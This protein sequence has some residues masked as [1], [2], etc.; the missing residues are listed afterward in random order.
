MELKQWNSLKLPATVRLLGH[1]KLI[2]LVKAEGVE[3]TSKAVMYCVEGDTTPTAWAHG[4]YDLIEEASMPQPQPRHFF[5]LWNPS[6]DKVPTQRFDSEKQAR[7]VAERMARQFPGET[8]Y[9]MRAVAGVTT[10]G[11][12]VEELA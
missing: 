11:V 7:K 8:F 5:I 2:R 3:P 1:D 4:L 10:T 9:V 6:S 12:T